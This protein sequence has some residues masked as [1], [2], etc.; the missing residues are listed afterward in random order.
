M[1]HRALFLDR[2]GTLIH[3]I[4]YPSHT[5][6]LHLYER[7]GSQLRTLQTMGFLLVVITNQSGIARGYFS[8][9]DLQCM[10]EH[11][12]AE[13]AIFGVQLTAIYYCPHHPEGVIPQFAKHCTCRKPQPGMLLQAS[14]DLNIDL[15]HSWFIGDTLSD[16]E[17]G[18]RA[19]CSTI[20][21]NL[22]NEVA[23]VSAVR[24][25]TFVVRSTLD[26]LYLIQAFERLSSK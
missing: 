10:H 9:I 8:E 16:I 6:D 25:P 26:A 24:R 19:G 13:L 14:S 11:L 23:S 22:D 4:P 20:L 21:L 2:D 17:A 18:N 15:R 1:K 5:K 7:I 3:P 12:M